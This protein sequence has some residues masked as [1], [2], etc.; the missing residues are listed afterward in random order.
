MKGYL[1]DTDICISLLRGRYGIKE[2]IQSV[3]VGSCAISE[4]T[5][6]ELRYGAENSTQRT[7]HLAEVQQMGQLFQVLLISPGF[8]HFA[9][10]KARLKQA[11]QLIPDFDL[12]IG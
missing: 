7:K 9:Q 11:G 2:K 3:G 6:L 5:L 4:I 10:E 1:L 12:L 8:P